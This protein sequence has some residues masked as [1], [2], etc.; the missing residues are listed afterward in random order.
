MSAHVFEPKKHI[1]EILLTF[2]LAIFSFLI[3]L[4]L[5]KVLK[6]ELTINLLSRKIEEVETTQENFN[7]NFPDELF[8]EHLKLIEKTSL[9]NKLAQLETELQQAQTNQTDELST[10]ISDVYD[11]YADFQAKLKRN[12]SYK[13]DTSK[14]EEKVGDW[15]DKILSQSFEE[16]S[17]EIS[18]ASLELDNDYK[19]YLATLP[20]PPTSVQGYTKTT[21]KTERGTTHTV[22]MVKSPLDSTKVKTVAAIDKDCS[23][24]CPTKTLAEYVSE[25][26]G[27]AGMNGSY[28]CPPDYAECAGKVNS[29]DF[30]LYDSND[31]KWLNKDALTWFKTGMIT[32]KGSN[33][34]FYKKTSEYGAG[35]VDAAVSNFPPLL[36][37]GEDVTGA[38][39]SEVT[40]YQKVKALRGAIGV[41]DKNVY[42]VHA[43]NASVEDMAYVMKALGVKNALNLDGGGTAAMYINGGYVVGPGRNLANAVVLVKK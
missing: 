40:A 5:T 42:L 17:A 30:A 12:E 26:G 7:Q 3:V 24:N 22:W 15:G 4:L 14:I 33:S 20:P 8:G 18:E 35:S 37:N 27:F 39:N 31:K 9:E 36:K 21:I 28:A 38:D 34:D 16:L 11:K 32:F 41:D 23:N 25:N 2:F 10:N 1:R 43:S 13:L 29:F 6:Q 19:D